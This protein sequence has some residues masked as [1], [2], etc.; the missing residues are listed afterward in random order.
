VRSKFTTTI[1]K[2]EAINIEA[3]LCDSNNASCSRR[4]TEDL[5]AVITLRGG[6]NFRETLRQKGVSEATINAILVGPHLKSYLDSQGR[7]TGLSLTEVLFLF[8]FSPDIYAGTPAIDFQDLV[9]KFDLGCTPILATNHRI[10]SE[11]VY[12]TGRNRPDLSLT[13]ERLGFPG[14]HNFDFTNFMYSATHFHLSNDT[15]I[16]QISA[17]VS[18]YND[19]YSPSYELN[20]WSSRE[21]LASYPKRGNIIRN[22]PIQLKES[23]PLQYGGLNSNGHRLRYATFDFQSFILPPG[24]YYLTIRIPDGRAFDL[25]NSIVGLSSGILGTDACPYNN[26]KLLECAP[27][28]KG[29]PA[30]DIYG[31]S[32][33][34]YA[35]RSGRLTEKPDLS[36]KK[37]RKKRKHH[38]RVSSARLKRILNLP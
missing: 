32:L 4:N 21:E 23:P 33:N 12:A 7:A 20:I 2:G 38:A 26:D 34:P 17:I 36:K 25:G 9:L 13:D 14:Y 24:D 3:M 22:R 8:E 30:V 37:K 6:E 16:S 11:L 5:N 18:R 29:T 28:W 31:T 19:D 27:F 35:S 15:I 1:T 10:N